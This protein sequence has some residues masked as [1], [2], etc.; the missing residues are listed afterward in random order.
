MNNIYRY[1]LQLTSIVLSIILIGLTV[2]FYPPTL[3]NGVTDAYIEGGMALTC[4]IFMF[5]IEKLNLGESKKI[6]RLLQVSS[7]ILY[8]GHLL[9]AIDELA[10]NIFIIDVAE[11]IFKLIGFLLFMFANF[12]WV[13]FHQQQS[14]L[15]K[16][17][18]KVDP[19]TGLLNRRAFTDIG[20]VVIR[21]S[22]R[23]HSPISLIIIDIDYFKR[24]ND[25]FG[26]QFG[27]KV[28]VKVTNKITLSL[29]GEGHI[30]RLGGEEFAVLLADCG[31]KKALKIAEMIRFNIENLP[32]QCC[33]Q[34]VA[35]TISLGITTDD[36]QQENLYQLIGRADTALYQAKSNGRNRCEVS[37][38]DLQLRTCC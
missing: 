4:L 33:G 3:I 35:T 12:K 27:D 16:K 22:N 34:K 32:I 36:S 20:S 37:E 17:L 25:N 21:D 29:D 6:Y 26:H 1:H 19:L 10:V 8:W 18:A 31:S 9:D 28:L 23:T 15:M 24:I 2:T 5:W 30:A 11:D 13:Q 14:S 38:S 7:L